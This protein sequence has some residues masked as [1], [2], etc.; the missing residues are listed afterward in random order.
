MQLKR[1]ENG[2]YYDQQKYKQCPHCAAYQTDPVNITQIQQTTPVQP[3]QQNRPQADDEQMT[4]RFAQAEMNFDPPV[5]WL[6]C[7]KGPN[8]GKEYRIRSERN[9]F[10]RGDQMDIVVKGDNGISRENHCVI[11]YNPRAKTFAL[12]PQEGKSIVYVGG[13]EVLSPV[14]LKPYDRIEVSRSA[15]VFVPLCGEA[16]CWEQE[17]E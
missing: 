7:V 9:R 4:V 5:G 14:Y 10:G 12:I 6:V 17:E 2:H 15:F 3:V 13:Q 11:S 16:F 8:K 1:C